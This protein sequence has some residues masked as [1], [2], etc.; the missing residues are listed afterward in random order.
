[1]SKLPTETLKRSLSRSTLLTTSCNIEE[2]SINKE[3]LLSGLCKRNDC[4]ILALQ[5]T[6]RGPTN[7]RPKIQ[8]MKLVVE[9]PHEKYESAIF[10]KQSLDL[11]STS[12]MCENDIEILTIEL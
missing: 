9:K 4:D 8:G 1:M 3:I 11:P 5:K 12:L 7:H 10:V 2:L 6:H